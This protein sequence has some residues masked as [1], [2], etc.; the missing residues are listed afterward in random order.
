M[1]FPVVV[2]PL[3]SESRDTSNPYIVTHIMSSKLGVDHGLE[4]GGSFESLCHVS[5]LRGR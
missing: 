4:L 3:I 5:P 2:E 1:W